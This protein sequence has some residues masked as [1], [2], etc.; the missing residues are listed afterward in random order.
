MHL[1]GSERQ[2]ARGKRREEGRGKSKRVR[3]KKAPEISPAL[4][5][6]T[7]LI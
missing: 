4:F 1:T 7:A 6:S 2:Q 5:T 3:E